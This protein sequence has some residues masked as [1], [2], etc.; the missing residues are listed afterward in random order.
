MLFTFFWCAVWM[1]FSTLFR[2]EVSI[3]IR[4]PLRMRPSSRTR[5]QRKLQYSWSLY[6]QFLRLLGHQRKINCFSRFC[7]LSFWFS[8]LILSVLMG[9]LI[10]VIRLIS[11]FSCFVL[12]FGGMKTLDKASATGT[13][14]QACISRQCRILDIEA[15]FHFPKVSGCFSDVFL[16]DL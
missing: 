15:A 1:A 9:H 6:G 12:L 7:V 5:S 10:P 13:W 11:C 3:T 14:Y 16:E 4:F 8:S 2:S